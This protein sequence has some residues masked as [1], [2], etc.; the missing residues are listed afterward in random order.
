MAAPADHRHAGSVGTDDSA[1]D[2]LL[3]TRDSAMMTSASS[4]NLAEMQA[5]ATLLRRLSSQFGEASGSG[6]SAVATTTPPLFE[7]STHIVAQ[8][9]SAIVDDSFNRCFA[10]TESE[11]WNWNIYL[12]PCWLV[13]V[14]LRYLVVFPIRLTLL[15]AAVLGGIIAM[16]CVKVCCLLQV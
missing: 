10:S 4:T 16:A 14:V 2:D 1:D 9:A 5:Q 12:F 8:G 3:L 7:L 15:L 11:P 13:G 6:E